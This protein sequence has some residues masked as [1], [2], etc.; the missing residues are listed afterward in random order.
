MKRRGFMLRRKISRGKVA[1]QAIIHGP[2]TRPLP[3]MLAKWERIYGDVMRL[4]INLVQ[5]G[6]NR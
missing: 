2:N 4:T 1:L 3:L 6:V 5:N